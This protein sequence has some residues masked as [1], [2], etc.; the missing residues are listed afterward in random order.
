MKLGTDNDAGPEQPRGATPILFV[1]AGV[2][3]LN[4][5]YDDISGTD[6][7]NTGYIHP[8]T[9]GS[10]VIQDGVMVAAPCG[11]VGEVAIQR[12]SDGYPAAILSDAAGA[13][14]LSSITP[15]GSHHRLFNPSTCWLA[16]EIREAFTARTIARTRAVRPP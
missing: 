10:R 9:G 13:C 12:R 1:H 7:L 16:V 2:N 11:A 3:V 14:T 8:V 6:S 15:D 4:D 5:V